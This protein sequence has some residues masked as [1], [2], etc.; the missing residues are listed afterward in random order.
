MPA[1]AERVYLCPETDGEP[2]WVGKFPRWWDRRGFFERFW[3]RRIDTGDPAY[4]DYAILLTRW[5]AQVWDRQCREEFAV[6]Q[7][8]RLPAARAM[9]AWDETL[10]SARWVIVE[11]YEWESGLD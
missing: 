3:E 11:S 7:R 10:K 6:R 9:E 4:V 1:R 2:G 8:D 5:E